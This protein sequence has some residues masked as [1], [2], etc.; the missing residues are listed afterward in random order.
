M[1]VVV[2]VNKVFKVTVGPKSSLVRIYGDGTDTFMDR[3]REVSVIRSLAHS[4]LAAPLH[5]TFKNGFVADFVVG[6][7]L[8]TAGEAHLIRSL[9]G[10]RGFGIVTTMTCVCAARNVLSKC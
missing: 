4:G 7:T 1:V 9:V 2:V 3:K 8:K 5:G 6:R 10:V